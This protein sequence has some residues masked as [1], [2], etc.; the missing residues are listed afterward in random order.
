MESICEDFD[1]FHGYRKAGITLAKRLTFQEKKSH[2][3]NLGTFNHF[4]QLVSVMPH[5]KIN[6]SLPSF[7]ERVQRGFLIKCS[8][9]V[10]VSCFCHQAFKVRLKLFT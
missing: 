1:E 2:A 3:M 4:C 10:C 8:S 7:H 6:F 9:C 5:L